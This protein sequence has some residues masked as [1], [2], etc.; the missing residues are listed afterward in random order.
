MIKVPNRTVG[1]Q[2][3]FNK[4]VDHHY[5]TQH[6][7]TKTKNVSVQVNFPAFSA[8][9]IKT[10][11]DSVFY[12]GL[13][14]QVFLSIITYLT[15]VLRSNIKMPLSDQTLLTLMRLRLGIQ[16]HD[17][18]RRF[19]ISTQLA[20]KIF[21]ICI[22]ILARK[23]KDCIVWLPRDV[24]RSAM[25]MSFK[26]TYPHTTCI[27][28][29]TEMFLQRPFS[30]KVRAQTYSTY[31]SHNTA[32][33][34]VAIAPN[35]YIMY[36]SR[37]YGGRASDVYITKNSGFLN[38]LLPGDEVMADRGFTISNE[39]YARRVKLNIPAFMKGRK[40]LSA[41]ECIE[42]RR[43]ASVRIHVERAIARLKSYRILN[44][45]LPLNSVQ[46]LDKIVKVCAVLCNLRPEL[47]KDKD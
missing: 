44:Q 2:V 22:S 46:K 19:S 41:T 18:G 38:Y 10:N 20:S 29:C 7:T 35:G 39:L 36:V 12:T 24:I 6:Y 21:G 5:A 33:I 47:I 15:S 17:L 30:L 23:L 3:H 45:V 4:S 31:K 25:P 32:K 26:T 28:D 14:L 42:T 34:L 37:C 27:I 16:F 8:D 40:Q 9:S 43:I 11:T 1:V 13:T